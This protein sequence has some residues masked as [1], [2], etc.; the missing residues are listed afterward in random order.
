MFSVYLIIDPFAKMNL[1]TEVNDKENSTEPLT[2]L[3]WV[4]SFTLN[5]SLKRT[6][7]DKAMNLWITL[8]LL[9]TNYLPW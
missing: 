8:L 6:A 5:R 2:A 7:K 1:F 9:F 4:L 3:I